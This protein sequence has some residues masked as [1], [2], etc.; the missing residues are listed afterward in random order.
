MKGK[1]YLLIGLVFG[2]VIG[3]A[4]GFL[5]LPYIEK[6]FSFLLGFITALAFVSLV[7]ILLTAWNRKFLLGLIGPKTV[8]GDSK[9]TRAHT[10][11]WIILVGI[12]VLGGV[13]GGLTLYR[14]QES[15]KLQIQNRDKKMQEM[16]ALM[17]SVKGNDLEPLMHRILDD[18]WE[19]LKH[20]PGRTL[21]DTTIARIAAISFSFKP[22][23]YI[24]GDSLSGA[25]YSP[26]RGQLLQAL[27]LMNIDTGSFAQIKRNASFAGADLR[28]ADL[29]RLDLS[30]INLKGANLKDADLSGVNL[31]GADLGEASLWGANLN[32]AN[33]SNANLKRT[34]LRWAQMNE[35]TLIL[36]NLSGAN[37]TNAQLRKADLTNA[38]FQWAQSVGTLFYEA[39][40][41]NVYFIGTDLSKANLNQANLYETDLRRINLSQ[42]DLVGVKLNKALVEENWLEKLKAWQPTGLKELEENYTVV[43]DTADSWKRPLYRVKKM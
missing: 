15:F 23:P 39:N 9:G 27:V 29:K 20:N 14:Q 6:D 40:L 7:L 26:E 17:E 33:L 41:T 2:I 13:L 5:R 11:I 25:P 8:T 43:N 35:A 3:W 4:L 42:A 16:A 37:L 36:A 31:K 38:T 30:G 19:K 22:Y 1:R 32:Q 34:D 28:G 24:E 18:V 10:F 21:S 12:L